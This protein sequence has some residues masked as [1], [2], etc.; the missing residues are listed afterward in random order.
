MSGGQNSGLD[1][2]VAARLALVYLRS[3]PAL[4]SL[5]GSQSLGH[6]PAPALTNPSCF[7]FSHLPARAGLDPG[8][9]GKG[10]RGLEGDW[11]WGGDNQP[12]HL[13]LS[14][15]SSCPPSGSEAKTAPVPP[16][17]QLVLLQLRAL[18]KGRLPPSHPSLS[19]FP[20]PGLS[21]PIWL[22]VCGPTAS[23]SRGREG[24]QSPVE[25]ILKPRFCYYV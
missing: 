12:R 6:A 11:G 25:L 24:L 22:P 21:L 8:I 3:P 17:A 1:R 13:F 16:L 4:L 23:E 20:F 14:V 5:W 18:G 9:W 2:L 19:D 15:L 7:C 10:H